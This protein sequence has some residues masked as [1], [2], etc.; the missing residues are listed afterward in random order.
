MGAEARARIATRLSFALL[1]IAVLACAVV[2]G[3]AW[4]P[5]SAE[6][7]G[8]PGLERRRTLSVETGLAAAPEG[9]GA[10]MISTGDGG[11]AGRVEGLDDAPLRVRRRSYRGTDAWEIGTAPGRPATYVDDNGIRLDDGMSDRLRLRAWPAVPVLALLGVVALGLARRKPEPGA[12][13]WAGAAL[14]TLAA[15]LAIASLITEGTGG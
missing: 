9:G 10:V 4:A 13:P 15:V 5:G 12:P 11:G 8:A 3:P 14:F 2:P 7:D 6:L 1:T